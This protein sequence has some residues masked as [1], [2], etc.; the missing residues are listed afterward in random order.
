[1]PVGTSARSPGCSTTSTVV[2]RSQP[3]S[4]GWAYAGRGTSGSRRVTATSSTRALLVDSAGG[5]RR[6]TGRTVPPYR[7]VAVL[8]VRQPLEPAL[9]KSVVVT[10]ANSG[11]G[12]VTVLELATAGYDVI[13]TVRSA[14]KADLVHQA[15]ADRG[16]T[17]RTV[18]L[19][20]N[21]PDSCKQ[22]IEEVADM[23]DGGPWAVVNNAGYA[24]AGAV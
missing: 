15:A 20:V 7:L 16:A 22:G 8:S 6:R 23:T 14:A 18:E 2:T 17:V 11:I 13:G 12:L 19:D 3:A 4:P 1:M 10:G 24:Q 21:D 5:I 9:S